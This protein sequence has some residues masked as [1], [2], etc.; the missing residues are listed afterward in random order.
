MR[1]RLDTGERR[2]GQRG[3]KETR[4]GWTVDGGQDKRQTRLERVN[5]HSRRTLTRRLTDEHQ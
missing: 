5:R 2:E 3:S 4:E 1:G